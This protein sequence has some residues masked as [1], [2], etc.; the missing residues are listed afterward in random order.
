MWFKTIENEGLIKL[1]ERFS[2][3]YSREKSPRKID[4]EEEAVDGIK[5][6][7]T[8]LTAK[9]NLRSARN[10]KSTSSNL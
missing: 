2:R 6:G 8:K 1:I 4:R 7:G 9:T 10:F 5:E 3:R